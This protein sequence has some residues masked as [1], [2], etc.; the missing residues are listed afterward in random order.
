MAT[1][2]SSLKLVPIIKC[3]FRVHNALNACA[4][5]LVGMTAGLIPTIQKVF[6]NFKEW[7]VAFSSRGE[8]VLQPGAAAVAVYD[9][10]GHHPRRV[11][12]PAAFKE[13]FQIVELWYYFQPHRYIRTESCWSEFTSCLKIVMSYC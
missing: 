9:D 13:K 5:F 12:D 11:R 3:K 10:Y 4:A 7:I 1:L 8:K 2:Q 6:S